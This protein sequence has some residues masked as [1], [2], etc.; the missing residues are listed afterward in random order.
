MNEYS[1]ALTP[2]MVRLKTYIVHTLALYDIVRYTIAMTRNEQMV[3]E[4]TDGDYA[5]NIAAKYGITT[6]QV[7]RI[8][9]KAGVIRS[10]SDSYKLAIK[11]GRMKYYYKPEH[12]K[13]KRKTIGLKLRF[14]V[15]N[16][17]NF[18]CVKCGRTAQQAHRIE[19]DHIDENPTNNKPDNL[20]TLCDLCNQ[21]KSFLA[22]F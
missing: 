11:Q 5:S 3:Q 21:G 2:D 10:I 14:E 7:Q 22:R 4:Y 1:S 13:K 15:L 17:D 19:I 12:L 9:N 20:Q 16:R 18:R 8:L 6:R